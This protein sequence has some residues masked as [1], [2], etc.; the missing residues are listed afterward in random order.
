MSTIDLCERGDGCPAALLDEA[1]EWSSRWGGFVAPPRRLNRAWPAWIRALARVLVG[2]VAVACFAA[3][4]ADVSSER[5]MSN[6]RDLP[7][8]CEQFGAHVKEFTGVGIKGE[9]DE[10][11]ASFEL[12]LP[13]LSALDEVVPEVIRGDLRVVSD[14]LIGYA[15]VLRTYGYDYRRVMSEGSPGEREMVSGGGVNSVVVM[16]ANAKLLSYVRASCPL[17]VVPA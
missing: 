3:A 14:S 1:R 10:L 17:V 13:S 9:P 5:D 12:L 2:L 8:F 15:A 16:A 11:Q 6:A 7:A 4:C